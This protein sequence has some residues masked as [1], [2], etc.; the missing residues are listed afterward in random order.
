MSQNPI[1]F[2]S[3]SAGVSGSEG[4]SSNQAATGF[5]NPPKR[6]RLDLAVE[7]EK[8]DFIA[9]TGI[10]S[11]E[12]SFL[13][14]LSDYSTLSNF[15]VVKSP[16]FG[17]PNTP[18][19]W[20]LEIVPSRKVDAE[21]FFGVCLRI[22]EFGE[23]L[24]SVKAGFEIAIVN[25]DKKSYKSVDRSL[26]KFEKDEDKNFCAFPK[27]I[28]TQNLLRLVHI[29]NDS[30]QIYC[31][32]W[33]FVDLTESLSSGDHARNG[34]E[35][36]R[37]S[38]KERDQRHRKMLANDLGKMLRDESMT[39]FC[40]KGESIILKVHKFILAARSP[41]FADMFSDNGSLENRDSMDINE[42]H[43]LVVKGMI[44]YFYTGKINPSLKTVE[45]TPALL[46]IASEYK[47]TGLKAELEKDLAN[48][49]DTT[50]VVKLLE[51]ALACDALYLKS[52][53]L[54]FITRNKDQVMQTEAF[55]NLVNDSTTGPLKEIF[56]LLKSIKREIE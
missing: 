48:S 7:L 34:I 14:N 55:Q 47:L 35:A 23:G 32:I 19:S 31:K 49:I 56:V 41:V 27:F 10:Q 16:S 28:P 42:Y 9:S 26:H 45:H 52:R 38:N 13:W 46:E 2:G 8:V 21:Y 43:G 12:F 17:S 20:Q 53:V 54:G 22:A 33:I 18:Y 39:D 29:C 6:Q 11:K 4:T 36:L 5:R 30:L 25:V 51:L 3:G 1:P 40:I 37:T 24:K 15:K 44:E 50:N